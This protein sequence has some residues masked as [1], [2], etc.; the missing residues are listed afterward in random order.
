VGNLSYKS[1]G[2]IDD[3]HK[4]DII[5]AFSLAALSIDFGYIFMEKWV[6]MLSIGIFIPFDNLVRLP[7]LLQ[8]LTFLLSLLFTGR[9]VYK[10]LFLPSK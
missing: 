10:I 6:E 5:L 2:K 7:Q 9:L 8:L 4:I 1:K 3:R